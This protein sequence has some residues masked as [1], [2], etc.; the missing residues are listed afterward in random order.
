MF[1]YYISLTVL[2]SPVSISGAIQPSVPVTPD[3]LEKETLPT[4]NFLHNPKSDIIALTSPLLFGTDI[5][6]L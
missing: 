3:L 2:S 4:C 6:T 5:N 1:I